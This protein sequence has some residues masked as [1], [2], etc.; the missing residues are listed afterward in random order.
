MVHD[1]QESLCLG[2]DFELDQAFGEFKRPNFEDFQNP[3]F[4]ES[5]RQRFKRASLLD[6]KHARF[7]SIRAYPISYKRM[8][9]I[10]SM[11]L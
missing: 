10:M 3:S 4:Q 11:S 7:L 1:K 8:H 5:N 6:E 9:T 2:F